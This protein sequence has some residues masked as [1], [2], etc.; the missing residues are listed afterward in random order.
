MEEAVMSG[1]AKARGSA[2]LGLGILSWRAPLTLAATL[3]NYAEN[4]LFEHF[5]QC[6]LF[7]Q[8]LSEHDRQVAQRF[9]LPI[10]GS[11]QNLG[12]LGGVTQLLE[13]LETEYVVLLENDCPLMETGAEAGRQLGAALADLQAGVAQL[14]RLRH[15]QQ[16]GE[17]FC[18]LGKYLR[19]HP[20][21]D[22]WL[23]SRMTEQSPGLRWVRR[24][25]RP[26]KARRLSGIAAYAERHPELY[27]AE[28]FHRSQNGN[29]ITSSHYLNWTNQSI[30][31]KRR[32]MLDTLL[33]WVAAHPSRRTVNGFP[34]IEKELNGRWWRR[35]AIPIGLTTPGL[36]THRRLDR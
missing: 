33:P 26:G 1:R 25:L 28:V 9:A 36:F 8:E 29:L 4:G 20:V 6:L 27:F 30:L 22:S 15:L 32:W 5:D 17:G 19:Y 24:W 35:Q 34:D 23:D 10:D 16:P 7:C 11:V 12:I 18:T 2:S 31:V 21:R 14:F 13:R 3:Q